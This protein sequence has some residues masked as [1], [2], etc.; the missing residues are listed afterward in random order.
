MSTDG[1]AS[2]E[3]HGENGFRITAYP[4]HYFAAIQSQNLAN[5]SKAL[6]PVG[7]SPLEW[8]I[9]AI[10]AERNGQTVNEI[11]A[12]A[13]ADRSKIS[14]AINKMVKNGLL[15]RDDA[16]IDRRRAAVKLTDQGQRIFGQA[17][18]IAQNVY[19]R[20]L[21]GITKKEQATLMKLLRRIKDNVFRL[22]AY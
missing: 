19:G 10:L 12:I 17:L 20:N 7:I 9:L 15:V 5:M 3:Q 11:T 16:A 2:D 6:A 8:R 1:N 14:R 13:V 4:M 18:L 21:E 22:E